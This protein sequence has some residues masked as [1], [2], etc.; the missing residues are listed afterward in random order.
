M[1][2]FNDNCV[3]YHPFNI[4]K[5]CRVIFILF[6]ASIGLNVKSLKIIVIKMY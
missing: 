3:F 6:Y 4:M 2:Y 1:F 5:I